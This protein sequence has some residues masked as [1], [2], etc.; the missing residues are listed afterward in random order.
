MTVKFAHGPRLTYKCYPMKTKIDVTARGHEFLFEEVA[1]AED[2]TLA[3]IFGLL[4]ASPLLVEVYRRNFA[5]QLQA[6]A[7]KGPLKA[8]KCKKS[9]RIDSLALCSHWHQD[10]SSDSISGNHL[11]HLD[12]QGPVLQKA[13]REYGVKAGERVKFS[14]SLTPL[15]ELLSLPLRINL[16]TPVYE[17]DLDAFL[18]NQ[19]LR[20]I[21][22]EGFTLGQVIQS[23]LWEL[24]FHGTPAQSAKFTASLKKEMDE[25]KAGTS[26]TVPV[27]DMFEGFD[28]PGVEAMFATIAN[29]SPSDISWALRS[30][31]DDG[32]VSEA[33]REQFA[34]S[35]EVKD[36]YKTLKG[37]EFRRT[38][39]LAKRRTGSG[40]GHRPQ[41]EDKPKK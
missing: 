9:E 11:L 36:E 18:C 6:E 34:D 21:R 27:G 35:V 22:Q 23:V 31:P 40:D 2:V 3:D 12:G 28:R 39:R 19:E 7:Q 20:A 8:K 17:A 15:R 30:I 38:F 14:V 13:S 25:I 37:R 29:H 4:E 24:S 32:D 41:N 26:K 5:Q 16:Q 10:T 1:L 33:L